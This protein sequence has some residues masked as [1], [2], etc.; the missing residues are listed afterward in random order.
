MD[1]YVDAL[2]QVKKLENK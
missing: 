2:N 1:D